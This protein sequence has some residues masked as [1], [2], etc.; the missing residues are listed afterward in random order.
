MSAITIN[1]LAALTAEITVPRI[2]VWHADVSLVRPGEV[3]ALSGPVVLEMASTTWRGTVR[4]SGENKGVVTVRIV[5]GADGLSTEIAAKAY[6]GV[7]VR[8]VVEE[9]LGEVGEVL[10]SASD[11]A[12]LGG[13]LQ[14][15]SR[16]SGGAGRALAA[17]LEAVGAKTWRMLPD[18]TLWIGND[19]WT[20]SAL[21]DYQ[22]IENAAGAGAIE[23]IA[24]DP[25]V[26]P[27]EVFRDRKVSAVTHRWSSRQLR[28]RIWFEDDDGVGE[29]DRIKA[30]LA[31]FVRAQFPRLDHFA[32]YWSRVV[33]QNGDG[34]LELIPDDPRIPGRSNVP[35]R[36]GVPGVK[37]TVSPGARVLLEFAGGDPSKPFAT[38]WESA[39]VTEIVVASGTKGAAR[40]DDTAKAATAMATWMAAVETAIN[41]IAPGSIS[42]LST[43]PVTGAAVA[44]GV[45]TGGSSIVKVG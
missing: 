33:S 2:G 13:V 37:A 18:G 36:Y 6:Q 43:V 31:A 28:T 24:W 23:I 21:E 34:T 5:G 35:I 12:I 26:F 9:L 27:G 14:Q 39:A 41:G 16:S 45:I 17:V 10:A 7:P 3:D 11:A 32:A 19:A 42:P 22:Y 4:R 1:G 29:Q 15:W 30:G 8:M 38:V 44:F 20:P 40:V 25:V